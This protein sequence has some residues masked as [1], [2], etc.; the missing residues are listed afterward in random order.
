MLQF[1]NKARLSLARSPVET[2]SLETQSA[3]SKAGYIHPPNPEKARIPR[4]SQP[5]RI[6]LPFR[7]E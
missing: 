5:A 6:I 3:P 4:D 1:D 7:R 2:G